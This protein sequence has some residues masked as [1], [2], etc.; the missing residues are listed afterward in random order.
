ME[1]W[2]IH[3]DTIHKRLQSVLSSIHLSVDIWTSLNRHLLLA[4]TADFV[5]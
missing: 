4:V 5:D 2:Q 3:K 1:S